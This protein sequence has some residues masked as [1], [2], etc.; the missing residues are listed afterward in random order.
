MTIQ[1]R[2][3]VGVAVDDSDATVTGRRAHGAELVG[4]VAQ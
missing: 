3:H 1:R 4:E 2:A